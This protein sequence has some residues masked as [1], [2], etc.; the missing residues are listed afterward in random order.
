MK[1]S[2]A[3]LICLALA[4]GCDRA[5]TH[6]P[7]EQPQEQQDSLWI[8]IARAII[9]DREQTGRPDTLGPVSLAGYNFARELQLSG[10]HAVIAVSRSRGGALML[11]GRDGQLQHVTQTREIRSLSLFDFDEDGTHEVVAEDCDGGTGILVCEYHV[12]RVGQSSLSEVWKAESSYRDAKLLRHG[13]IRFMPSRLVY[14][15]GVPGSGKL[16]ERTFV[17][18]GGSF[19]EASE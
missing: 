1:S 8:G 17:Y 6:S 18:R 13:L 15:H 2:C 11:F 7:A 3:A 4:L 9:R 14:A 19:Q 10:E 12:Y 16:V 5:P